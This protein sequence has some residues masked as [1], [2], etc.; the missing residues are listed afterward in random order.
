MKEKG[1]GKDSEFYLM[2]WV[3][4]EWNIQFCDTW[5]NK[6][7]DSR[8]TRACILACGHQGYE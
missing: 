8:E 2:A 1:K 5:H 6:D 7:L 3:I 4:R